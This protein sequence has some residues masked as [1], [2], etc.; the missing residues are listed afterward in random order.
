V[1]LIIK[2]RGTPEY[3]KDGTI[4]KASNSIGEMETGGKFKIVSI[5]F[6]NKLFFLSLK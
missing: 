6:V 4:I 1:T 2:V 5:G 3:P